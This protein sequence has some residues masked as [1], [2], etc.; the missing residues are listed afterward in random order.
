[1]DRYTTRIG[2]IRLRKEFIL[3]ENFRRSSTP[4]VRDIEIGVVLRTSRFH[5]YLRNNRGSGSNISEIKDLRL[6]NLNRYTFNG[7]FNTEPFTYRKRQDSRLLGS[8]PN[9]FGISKE[10]YFPGIQGKVLD[11]FLK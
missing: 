7:N 3:R 11:P 10:L 6:Y 9:R 4:Y 8:N 5:K 1:L 2:G